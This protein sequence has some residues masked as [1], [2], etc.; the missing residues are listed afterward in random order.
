MEGVWLVQIWVI[1]TQPMKT[2]G[3]G[4]IKQTECISALVTVLKSNGKKATGSES[5]P[6]F[7]Q[8]IHAISAALFLQSCSNL[9]KNAMRKL[10]SKHRCYPNEW[11]IY[12]PLQNYGIKPTSVAGCSQIKGASPTGRKSADNRRAI[13][14]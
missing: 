1:A 8:E 5:A 2:K 7:P 14:G 11:Y 6:D 13:N 10:I 4:S 3:R 12:F 9:K